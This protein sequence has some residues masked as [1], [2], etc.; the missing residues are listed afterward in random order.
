MISDLRPKVSVVIPTFNHG[1]YIRRA[2]DSVISQTWMCFEIIVVDNHS[3]DNTAEVIKCIGDVRIKHLLINN[4]GI[5]AKSRNL[6]LSVACGD[7]IAFLDSDDWWRSDK[8][9]K[10]LD[11]DLRNVDLIYHDL[12]IKS[13]REFSWLKRKIKSWQV[14]SPV[15]KDLLVRGNAIANSSVVVRRKIMLA[16]S[17]MCE[18]PEMVAAEDYNTWL[19]IARITDRFLYINKGLGFYLIHGFNISKRDVAQ[20]GRISVREYLYLLSSVEMNLLESRFRNTSGRCKYR[21]GDK[22]A[23]RQD[24]G[25]SL[26]NGSVYI[27]FKSGLAMLLGELFD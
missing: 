13:S 14:V 8:I 12:I 23:A 3:T 5:I 22:L 7:W 21:N 9:E 16:V 15:L 10:C 4:Q 11:R 24:L 19:N 6:G 25:F 20:A 17:G 1:Q 2:L 27:R 26:R 18:D